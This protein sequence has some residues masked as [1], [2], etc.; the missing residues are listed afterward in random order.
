MIVAGGSSV[1]PPGTIV[2]VGGVSNQRV[3]KKTKNKKKTKKDNKKL[4]QKV[5][6]MNIG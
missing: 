5:E 2:R 4:E 6:K 3:T 1:A